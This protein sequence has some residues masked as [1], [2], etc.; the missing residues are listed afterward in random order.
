MHVDKFEQRSKYPKYPKRLFKVSRPTSTTLNLVSYQFVW[1]DAA[2][3]HRPACTSRL[4]SALPCL[5]TK[6][7]SGMYIG[8]RATQQVSCPPSK[9][10][11]EEG[12]E[13]YGGGVPSPSRR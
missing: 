13:I 6:Q 12:R 7:A 3:L 2:I 4:L 8:S 5:I 9:A 11:P 10:H 1:S